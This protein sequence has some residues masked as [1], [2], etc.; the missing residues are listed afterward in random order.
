MVIKS[1]Q[2][3]RRFSFDY[4][5]GAETVLWN[6]AKQLHALG[7][8]TEIL[9]TSALSVAGLEIRCG[10]PIRRFDYSYTRVGLSSENKRKLDF[11]GGNAY[12]IAMLEFM[13]RQNCDLLHCHSS[14]RIAQQVN[15]AAKLLN[16]PY[17]LTLHGD[18]VLQ[19]REKSDLRETLRY[20]WDYGFF[21]DFFIRGK[22]YLQ[23]AN[24]II[25]NNEDDYNNLR[26]R[27]PQK[28]VEFIPNGVNYQKFHPDP[29][30][31]MA[32]REKYN[33]P[34]LDK[35]ILCVSRLDYNKNQEIIIDLVSA[36]RKRGDKVH[37][38]LVGNVT[39]QHYVGK[40][41]QKILDYDIKENVT[42]IKGVSTD[43]LDLVSAYASADCFILPSVHEPFGIVCLEAWAS[44]TPVIASRIGGLAKLIKNRETGLFF[45]NNSL[46]KLIEAYDL[47]QKS[48]KLREH[49]INR[50]YHEVVEKYSWEQVTQKLLVFY[51]RVLEEYRHQSKG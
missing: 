13:R 51:N 32:F 21:Y 19:P 31:G 10:L 4:W 35:V 44:K 27:F 6:T 38:V 28:L 45:E 14:D 30:L 20:S 5:G 8:T 39:A 9:V 40:I 23:Q 47:Y 48:D 15:F 43:D 46:T 42:I 22:K 36:L 2:I 11:K 18:D 50:A 7:N 49:V 3:I 1:L 26:L 25:C 17:I 29:E 33:I 12:S 24:G 37:A 41:E 16:V 34:K